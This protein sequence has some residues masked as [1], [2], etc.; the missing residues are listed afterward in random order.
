M[1][2]SYTAPI[3]DKSYLKAETKRLKVLEVLHILSLVAYGCTFSLTFIWCGWPGAF[4]ALEIYSWIYSIFNGLFI[5]AR[6][7]QR[8]SPFR[9]QHIMLTFYLATAVAAALALAFFIIGCVRIGQYNG[10]RPYIPPTDQK[11]YLV[12]RYMV[13]LSVVTIN[14]C[15]VFV[16]YIREFKLVH[17]DAVPEESR[18]SNPTTDE[19]AAAENKY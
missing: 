10:D 14:L 11:D 15:A 9:W 12:G 2:E 13:A 18:K 16:L 19:E 4:T 1:N 7:T 8:L 5:A 3:V 6:H 17:I